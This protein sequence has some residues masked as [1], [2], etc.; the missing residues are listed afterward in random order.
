[1][2]VGNCLSDLK[3]QGKTMSVVD[4]LLCRMSDSAGAEMFRNENRNHKQC[5]LKS[6]EK[7]KISWRNKTEQATWKN[8][9]KIIIDI[10]IDI[11][12]S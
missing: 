11:D 4:R 9:K 12:V 6:K 2:C 1:M 5:K 3:A 8:K 10:W 7:D